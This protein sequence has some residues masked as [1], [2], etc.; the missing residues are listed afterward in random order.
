[1]NGQT[2]LHYN[3]QEE[4]G[5]GGQGAVYKAVD[6]KLGRTVVI[7]ILSP[8]L[9]AKQANLK[10]F[11]R[12]ARLASS[13]DHPNIC[14]I[15]DLNEANGTHFI[16]MQYVEG[17]NVRQLV[18]GRP[19][20]LVSAL[21]IALQV[22]DALTAA[23]ERGIIHR[24]IKA[25]NVMVTDTGTVKVLDFGLAKLLDE[26]SARARDVH[27]T[28]L[29]EFGV[30]YGTATYAAPEQARGDADV[31]ARADIFSMGVLLYE[32]LTG[33]WPFRG[34]T[35]IDVRHA[36]L[37]D[38]PQP[39]VESR[40]DLCPPRLQLI[41]DRALQKEPRNRYQKMSEFRDDLRRALSESL[42]IAPATETTGTAAGDAATRSAL[43]LE[44]VA[45][46]IMPPV[47]PRHL[48]GSGFDAYL[49]RAWRWLQNLFGIESQSTVP[50]AQA[51]A[52]RAPSVTETTPLHLTSDG[53]AD[54]RKSIAILPFRNLNNDAD[55][56]FYEFSLSDAV[57]TEL[58][59]LRSLVVRPSFLVAKYQGKTDDPRA[60]GREL[61][62]TAVL[63]ASFLKAGERFRVTAQLLDV[64]SGDML[65]SDRVDVAAGDIIGVQDRIAQHIV[66]GLRIE[67]TP[68]EQ[69]L[70]ARALTTNPQAYEEYLRGR[71]CLARY[72]NRTLSNED[73]ECAVK[74]FSRATEL[75]P[76][77]ALAH[78][79]IGVCY[80]RRVI[81]GFGDCKDYVRAE[82]EFVAALTTDPQLIEA[83]LHM[84]YIFLSRGEK[85]R[86]REEVERLR[87][88][89]P[90][91][92]EAQVIAGTVYRL[93]GKYDKALR[94]FERAAQLNPDERVVVSYNQA[95]VL[96]Y[97]GRYREATDALDA[98]ARLEPNHPLIKT[99]RARICFYQGD[100]G[101]A[102]RIL[103]EVLAENPQMDGIR[104]ILAM[105]LSA[106]G[107][108]EAARAE[109]TP[110]TIEN[111]SAD[112]D[113]AYWLASAYALET[114]KDEAF[115][116]LE[117]AIALG[118]ENRAWFERDPNWAQLR[119][120]ARFKALMN[121]NSMATPARA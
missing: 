67:L 29:T 13:L 83:R 115:K 68:D 8:E 114:N 10:R 75:D 72:A 41:L 108:H 105:C 97:E 79:G 22:A 89:A 20:E 100:A 94:S 32:L 7:K 90:N 24:D 101:E 31:D 36:V 54:V 78:S 4:L 82:A 77:F 111:A 30:P 57:T 74:H 118:N 50:R 26:E 110:R 48:D 1:M 91:D 6:T 33:T 96:M 93:D 113:I 40:T 99:F 102:T 61:N 84:I 95:R 87:R 49:Q 52:T 25:G 58:A 11:E 2:L 85:T 38:T 9:T 14:T 12:E 80:T 5:K 112:H 116:W 117:R 53:L 65:W 121:N 98:G 109:L 51:Q 28:E 3:L 15:F 106:Q 43:A 107:Q 44:S 19:L 21:S 59:R 104:P 42:A 120:D 27:H 64:A 86:A 70:F 62:V 17:R 46:S 47:A 16:A 103:R 55:T 60:I 71:D 81:K 45:A 76:S 88:E 63:A 23:H 69:G 35:S 73:F 56:A 119:E 37:H 39:I 66:E 18:D 34:Q 92:A